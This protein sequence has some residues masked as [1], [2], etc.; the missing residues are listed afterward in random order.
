MIFRNILHKINPYLETKQVI[1]INGLRRTGKTTLIKHILDNCP[2]SNKIFFDFER[3]ENRY[4]F[5]D[6]N[7]G[8]I[9]KALELEGIDFTKKI[10]IALDEIQLVKNIT[11]LIK[12]LYDSYEIKF[13]V[14]GSSSYY[15]KNQFSE[16]LAGRKFLFTLNTLSFDEFL[17]FRNIEVKLPLFDYEKANPHTINKLLPFYE[18]YITFGGFP[19]VA[20]ISNPEIKRKYLSDILN[21][22]LQLDIKFLADFSTTDEVYKLIRLLSARVGSK[23]DYSKLSMVSGIHRKKV[24]D[25]LL[26]LEQTYFIT[27]VAP[28]VVNTDREIALQKKIYFADTG[29]LNIV[30]RVNSGALFENAVANQL[31]QL[32]TLNYYA[33]RSGQEINFILN[34]NIAL[35]VKETASETDLNK[36]KERATSIKINKK[37]I[38]GKNLPPSGFNNFIWGGN[39]Y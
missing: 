12:Y 16:S 29:L 18:E 7:F 39:I 30:G 2:G 15:M 32:G 20:T 5:S 27:L 36:L 22:Y 19:E 4:L 1:A 31:S 21:S 26:F 23:V 6:E 33:K 25:Y 13:L 17:N 24:K 10:F 28:Y 9:I 11:G 8:N 14:T 35:E 37:Y 38:I 34:E 3:A